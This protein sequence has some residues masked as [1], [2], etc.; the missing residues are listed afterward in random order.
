MPEAIPLAVLGRYLDGDAS[1]EER[2]ADEAWIGA[3]P[4]RRAAVTALHAPWTADARPL[5]ADSRVRVPVAF[6]AR[7]RDVYLEGEAYFSVVHDAARSVV[8]HTTRSKVS[9][10]GTKFGVHAYGDAP[11]ERV[12]VVEG[13]VALAIPEW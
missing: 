11:S 13:A 1:T 12:A 10:L 8:V 7:E 5:S 6:G 9:D 2:A 4:A 3:D